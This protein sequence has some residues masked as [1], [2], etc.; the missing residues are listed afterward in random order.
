MKSH[1]MM[2]QTYDDTVSCKEVASGMGKCYS[3]ANKWAEGRPDGRSVELNPLDR[4][5]QLLVVTNDNRLLQWL[6]HERGGYFTSYPPTPM[7][8]RDR[9]AAVALVQKRQ[10]RLEIGL[11]T[12][13]E[14]G[15]LTPRELARLQQDLAEFCG[16]YHHLLRAYAAKHYPAPRLP[17]KKPAKAKT[18]RNR[19]LPLLLPPLLWPVVYEWMETM[20]AFAA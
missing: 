16:H 5:H 13:L 7:L 8:P 6:C 10:G 12:L 17:A 15:P 9:Q 1:E 11:G 14:D 19:K 20:M 18:K 2:R 4:L 3:L